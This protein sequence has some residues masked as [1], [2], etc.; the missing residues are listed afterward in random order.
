MVRAL[1]LTSGGLDSLLAAVIVQQMGVEVVAVTFTTFFTG[2]VRE[3]EE[4]K[5]VVEQ[6]YPVVVVPL[7]MEYVQLLRAPKHGFGRN[8]NP[9]IDCHRLMLQK[10]KEL[11]PRHGADFLV[12]GEV[13]G[14]RPMSQRAVQQFHDQDVAL[15]LEGLVLRPLS[16]KLLPVTIPEENGWVDRD[17]LYDISGRTRTRQ[18]ALAAE[19]GIT[20]FPNPAGGCLLTDPH[21]TRRLRDLLSHASDEELEPLDFELL[22]RGRHLRLSP[23]VKLIVG[24]DHTENLWLQEQTYREGE[25]ILEPE[26]VTGPLV[27][28]RGPAGS[29]DVQLGARALAYY[30]RNKLA[31][32]D[33]CVKQIDGRDH[34]SIKR[35]QVAATDALSD[36]DIRPLMDPLVQ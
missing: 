3:R 19:L 4:G 29:E 7:G 25:F 15:G 23:T 10:A 9:C 12:T 5:K 35:Y 1:A 34:S 30:C 21:F 13:L 33:L 2:S 26:N 27:V 18:L 24:R 28:L 14:Q 22:R 17:Q 32:S 31:G 8:L 6:H 20:V 16:A 11:M 36:G